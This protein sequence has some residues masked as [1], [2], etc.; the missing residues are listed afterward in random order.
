MKC[1]E[2]EDSFPFTWARYLRAPLGR[3]NCPS[4]GA[5]LALKHRWFYW[6]AM[7]LGGALL[8]APLGVLG[9]YLTGSVIV[10][11]VAAGVGWLL[12]GVP[13]DWYLESRFSIPKMVGC[14]IVYPLKASDVSVEN[15]GDEPKE[16]QI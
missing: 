8:G 5:R 10:T 9:Y 4:C 12:S 11:I 1:P 13:A 14:R 3:T 16:E 7:V 15:D 2:C 6:P